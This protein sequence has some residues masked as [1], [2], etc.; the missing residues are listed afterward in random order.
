MFILI[1]FA[2]AIALGIWQGIKKFGVSR[3]AKKQFR[4]LASTNPNFKPDKLFIQPNGTCFIAIDDT[5][6]QFMFGMQLSQAEIALAKQKNKGISST[7]VTHKIVSYNDILRSQIIVD[8]NTSTHYH[9][10][11]R[12]VSETINTIKL[13]LLLNDVHNSAYELLFYNKQFDR[14]LAKHLQSECEKWQDT[15]TVALNNKHASTRA[16]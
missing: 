3:L 2:I 4:N 8:V 13:K 5:T 11:H 6:K 16:F 9:H 10:H 1:L 15:L 14:P 7:V 12:H